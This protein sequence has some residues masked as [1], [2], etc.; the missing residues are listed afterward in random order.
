MFHSEHRQ[1]GIGMRE[2]HPDPLVTIHPDTGPGKLGIKDGDWVY[3]EDA[4]GGRHQAAGQPGT[5][6][7]CRDVVNC[8]GVPGGFPEQPVK[9]PPSSACSSQ[10][11]N[12]LTPDSDE[13]CDLLTGG[14]GQPRFALPGL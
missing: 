5:R 7:S 10:T 14:L 1:L 11:A 12:V 9:T 8:R 3:I 4:A 6:A 2:R 13:F